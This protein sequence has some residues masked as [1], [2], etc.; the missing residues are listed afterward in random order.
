MTRNTLGPV[1]RSRRGGPLN[2]LLRGAA[3]GAAGTTALNATTYLDMAIRGR[4]TSSAPE[5]LVEKGAGK[6]GLPIPGDGEER[7]NRL[8]GLGPLSGIAVGTAVGAVAGGLHRAFANR[9][10]SVPA[11]IAA[12]LIGAAAMALSDVPLKVLGI[13][14]PVDWAA[15][16]WAADAVPHLVY[17]A[18]TYATIRA[19]DADAP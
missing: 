8:A 3:A 11:P 13:S 16:D 4:G 1:G 18:V 9:G 15:P 7:D 14:D 17:G 19:T 12:V 10:R 5:D 6:A 2:G